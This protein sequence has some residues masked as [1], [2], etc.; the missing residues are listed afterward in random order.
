MY[1]YK[2]NGHKSITYCWQHLMQIIVLLPQNWGNHVEVSQA[3]LGYALMSS[4]VCL[5]CWHGNELSEQ[6]RINDVFHSYKYTA[7]H[8]ASHFINVQFS[9]PKTW[10][11]LPASA[12]GWE[13]L[14]HFSAVWPS[15]SP[16]PARSSHSQPENLFRCQIRPWWMYVYDILIVWP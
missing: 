1:F 8:I 13:L 9:R 3:I 10:E 7:Y 14:S 2:I 4:Y 15:S 12:T 11:T 5:I 16:Q 6:V